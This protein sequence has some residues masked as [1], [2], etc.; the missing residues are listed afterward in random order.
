MEVNTMGYLLSGLSPKNGDQKL[1]PTEL[2][3]AKRS[4]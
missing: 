2:A 4:N 1:T 3:E